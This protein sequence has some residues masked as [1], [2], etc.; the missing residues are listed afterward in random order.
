MSE[1]DK[2]FVDFAK[3]MTV[4]GL[5][6]RETLRRAEKAEKQRRI[7]RMENYI[8]FKDGKKTKR[9]ILLNSL[10]R[11]FFLR[12]WVLISRFGTFCLRESIKYPVLSKREIL[13]RS[14][15]FFTWE[16]FTVSTSKLSQLIS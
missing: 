12:I 11:K 2:A 6:A 10:R 16:H 1:L 15:W 13:L 3:A 8:R 14:V 4:A 5:N 7:L 9:K